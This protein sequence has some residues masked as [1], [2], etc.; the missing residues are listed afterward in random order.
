MDLQQ[1]SLA[2]RQG[3]L[4]SRVL[5]RSTYCLLSQWLSGQ[6]ALESIIWNTGSQSCVTFLCIADVQ[7]SCPQQFRVV[8]AC[9]LS[10]AKMIS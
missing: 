10:V 2:S 6:V 5:P 1:G 4:A 9:F 7:V 8:I 3:S